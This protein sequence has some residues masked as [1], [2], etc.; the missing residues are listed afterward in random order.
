MNF[1]HTSKKGSVFHTV[2]KSQVRVRH[3][4]HDPREG[5]WIRLLCG[6]Q[7]DFNFLGHPTQSV[8]LLITIRLSRPAVA[9]SMR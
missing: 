5:S 3:R 4:I 8:V 6:R 7:I 9:E 2:L 1:I